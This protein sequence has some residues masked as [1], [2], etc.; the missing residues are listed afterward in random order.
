MNIFFIKIDLSVSKKILCGSFRPVKVNFWDQFVTV[1]VKWNSSNNKLLK[2]MKK[3]ITIFGD[4]PG[5]I[6]IFTNFF[7]FY[8]WAFR[9]GVMQQL[10]RQISGLF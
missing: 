6:P 8:G 9:K 10:R 2:K 1:E 3:L 7:Q 4:F 5:K